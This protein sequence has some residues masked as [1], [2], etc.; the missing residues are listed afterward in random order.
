MNVFP[1]A[2]NRLTDVIMGVQLLSLLG[3][4]FALQGWVDKKAFKLE[5]NPDQ[6]NLSVFSESNHLAKYDPGPTGPPPSGRRGGGGGR[7]V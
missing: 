2:K 1:T 6:I 7:W 3:M 4:S 5:T